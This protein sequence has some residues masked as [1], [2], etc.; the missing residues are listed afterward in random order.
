MEFGWTWLG[1]T[2]VIIFAGALANGYRRGFVK[3]VVSTLFVL[4]S[5]VIVWVINPYVNDFVREN[6][7]IY[8]MIQEKSQEF[9]ASAAG[10]SSSSLDQSQQ[11]ELVR[12]MNLPRLL[13]DGIAENNTGEAYKHMAVSTFGDYVSGYLANVAVNSLSFVISYI[14]ATLLIRMIT[15]A[16]NIL[17]RL[18][19]IRGINK[20]AGAGVG[21][22]KCILFLWIAMLILTIF[23]NTEFGQQGL[24]LIDDDTILSFLYE[25]N[26]F[27]KAFTGI[28][29]H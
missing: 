24:K 29:Y 28:F 19:V 8:E 5:F 18:P 9:V 17:A 2:A 20:L 21:G 25:H 14:L 22:I 15:Y 23:C 12:N 3:E 6:T 13:Q 11:D 1:I 4:L 7:H 27:I 10:E 16:L 26:I